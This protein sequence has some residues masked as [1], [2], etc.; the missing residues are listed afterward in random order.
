M[1]IQLEVGQ[2]GVIGDFV[3]SNR[4]GGHK[5]FV[6]PKF[7]TTGQTDYETY[8]RAALMAPKVGGRPRLLPTPQQMFATHVT[9]KASDPVDFAT[10]FQWQNARPVRAAPEK[11]TV[12]RI[13]PGHFPVRIK[14]RRDG[15]VVAELDVWVVGSTIEPTEVKDSVEISPPSTDFP[16]GAIFVRMGF[17]FVHRIEPKTIIT[18]KDRPSL[19]GVNKKWPPKGENYDGKNLQTGAAMKWDV[20][21]VVRQRVLNPHR[22]PLGLAATRRKNFLSYPTMRDGDGIPEKEADPVS[23][24]EWLIVGNDDTENFVGVTAADLNPYDF[25]AKVVEKMQGV[26]VG[27]GSSEQGT[28]TSFDIPGN[29]MPHDRGSDGDTVEW[30]MHFQEFTRLEINEKWYLIS[31]R[32]EWR[33]H[34]KYIKV[35]G[36][37]K[38]NGSAKALDNKNF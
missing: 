20:S 28:L 23:F 37:W 25:K 29:Q 16:Q 15:A 6:T 4:K 1:E 9:L 26:P 17:S 8:W 18:A 27:N 7:N 3:P 22:V 33:V 34:N 31:K 36:K 2:I 14:R 10:K 12:S 35:K 13:V 11:A 19:S 24:E 38:D 5:H 32:L 21:R 30:R